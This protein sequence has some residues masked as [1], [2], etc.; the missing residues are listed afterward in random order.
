[1][2]YVCSEECVGEK[3]KRFPT[4]EHAHVSGSA[5]ADK[6]CGRTTDS[7]RSCKCKPNL[8][9]QHHSC[10]SYKFTRSQVALLV[11][12]VEKNPRMHSSEFNEKITSLL[13]YMIFNFS[14]SFSAFIIVC[15]VYISL[16]YSE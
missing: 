4:G 16:I 12:F 8:N 15:L 9:A 13:K 1:M 7:K 2:Q 11:S 5:A 6:P 14:L 3:Y 10:Y